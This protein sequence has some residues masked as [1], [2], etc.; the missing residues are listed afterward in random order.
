MATDDPIISSNIYNIY[1]YGKTWC[2]GFIFLSCPIPIWN[3]NPCLS[4]SLE[5]CWSHKRYYASISI[6]IY[7]YLVYMIH[8][9]V[10]EVA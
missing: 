5:G 10:Q 6:Y 3:D 7:V 9:C 4:S 2:S 8:G 1:I